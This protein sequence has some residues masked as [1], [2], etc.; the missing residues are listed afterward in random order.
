[1]AKILYTIF[2]SAMLILT[3]TAFG[4]IAIAYIMEAAI[5][6]RKFLKSK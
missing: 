2:A 4:A 1:M 3:A 6:I 5:R